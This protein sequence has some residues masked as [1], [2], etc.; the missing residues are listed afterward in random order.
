MDVFSDGRW[1]WTMSRIGYIKYYRDLS[2][3]VGLPDSVIGT[4]LSAMEKMTIDNISRR[5]RRPR[6]LQSFDGEIGGMGYTNDLKFDN[7]R[8]AAL[9]SAMALKWDRYLSTLPQSQQ[10]AVPSFSYMPECGAGEQLFV[11]KSDPPGA[12]IRII[13]DFDWLLCREIGRNPWDPNDCLGWSLI[14]K[15]ENSLIGRY[16][17]QAE[18]SNGKISR[19]VVEVEQFYGNRN[20][21]VLTFR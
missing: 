19:N 4:E 15:E 13:S 20:D 12:K 16:R 17:Y 2:K 10:Q 5:L 7:D 3:K 9:E 8:V 14:V 21:A 1:A 6:G 11:V 18:W